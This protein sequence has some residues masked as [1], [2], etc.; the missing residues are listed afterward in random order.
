MLLRALAVWCG[1]AA[2]AVLNGIFRERI[3]TPRLGPQGG[4][5]LSTLALCA[6]ITAV[7]WLALPWLAPRTDAEAWLI[8]AAWLTWTVAFE[9]LAGHYLFG[10]PWSRL[11]A[12]YNLRRGR[13]WVFVL[14]TSLLAPPTVF[15]LIAR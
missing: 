8:G 7:T 11:V 14:V 3:F 5:V 2:L 12:D 4:H 1:L 13:I 10:H 15:S 9:F 6:V